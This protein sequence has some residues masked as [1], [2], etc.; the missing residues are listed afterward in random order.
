[1]GRTERGRL[2]AERDYNA[3]N[4]LQRCAVCGKWFCRRRDNVCSIACKQKAE[5]KATDARQ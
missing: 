3:S 4:E 2:N 5:A 1:M